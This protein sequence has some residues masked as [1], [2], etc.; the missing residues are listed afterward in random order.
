MNDA[1]RHMRGSVGNRGIAFITALAVIVVIASVL[2]VL[3]R[4]VQTE[5]LA[6][7]NHAAATEARWIAEGVARALLFELSDD[8]QVVGPGRELERVETEGGQLGNG[9]YWLLEP[10]PED[11]GRYGFGVV[12]ETGKWNLNI[13]TVEV[14]E[15]LHSDVTPE[16]AEAVVAWRGGMAGEGEDGSGAGVGSESSYYLAQPRPYRAKEGPFETVGELLLVRGVGRELVYGPR[17]TGREGMDVE[18]HVMP[19]TSSHLGRRLQRGLAPVV[20]VHS[21]EPNRSLET[22]SERLDINSASMSDVAE[23]LR[24]WL[25]EARAE[26]M[27]A[28]IASQRPYANMLEVLL[29]VEASEDEAAQLYDRLTTTGQAWREGLIDVVTASA[30]ALDALPGLEPGDGERL[31][32][33]RESVD[34]PRAS[35]MWVAEAIGS[36]K[37][38]EIGDAITTRSYQFSA[39]ILAVS[40]NGRAFH[41]MRIVIDVSPALAGNPARVVYSEALTHLGW[42]LDRGILD[43]LR[44]GTAPAEVARR[45]RGREGGV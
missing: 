5:S 23:L 32:G 19:R 28:A 33:A 14:L 22:G 7:V 15:A 11:E 13:A 36:E 3:V 38:V 29:R 6:S 42:P 21:R 2:M 34:D 30:V 27:V 18:A 16:I 25:D 31:I 4:H 45:Y 43:A 17:R 20:T 35:P 41:R 8:P 26:A 39:D 24:E 12:S 9:L 44:A 1:P 10:D 40:G 37:A